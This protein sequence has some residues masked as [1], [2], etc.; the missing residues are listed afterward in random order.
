MTSAWLL[1]NSWQYSI[2]MLGAGKVIFYDKISNQ[3]TIKRTINE[4]SPR[5]SGH[6]LHRY[7]IW[8]H[9]LLAMLRSPARDNIKGVILCV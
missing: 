7:C 2:L 8:A 3:I 1:I 9:E 4:R 6:F 5:V